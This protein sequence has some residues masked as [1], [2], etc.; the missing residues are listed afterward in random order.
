MDCSELAKE[1]SEPDK[2]INRPAVFCEEYY[3]GATCTYSLVQMKTLRRTIY[4]ENSLKLDFA[5]SS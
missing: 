3:R 4:R 1:H 5:V 2:N